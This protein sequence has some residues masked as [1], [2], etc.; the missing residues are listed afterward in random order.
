MRKSVSKIGHVIEK[1][2]WQLVS[3]E[4]FRDSWGL[5]FR[6]RSKEHLLK[7]KA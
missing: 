4:Q 3:G 5:I 6:R 7:G 1:K 2:K